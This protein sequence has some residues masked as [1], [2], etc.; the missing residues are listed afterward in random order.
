MPPALI[1]DSGS[2]VAARDVLHVVYTLPAPIA[3]L[4]F[5]TRPS[6]TTSCS[7]HRPQATLTIAR[8][9]AP[10]RR[11][12]RRHVGA[13]HLGSAM[14]HHPH[15]H[16]IVPGGGL[17]DDGRTWIA[18]RPKFF[19]PVRVLSRLFRR[20]VDRDAARRPRR[21]QAR[22]LRHAHQPRSTAAAFAALLAPLEELR[23]GRLCEETVRRARSR[24]RLS[25]ALHPPRRHLEPPTGRRRRAHRRV[26]VQGLSH[27]RRR[28]ASRS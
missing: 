18:C 20:L 19:L 4:A 23:M 14:T 12:D 22:L 9:Q 21:R 15:V 8:R 13:A 5:T 25:L 1:A 28:P 2:R 17:S 7:G 27:R 24:A 26:Q 6:S 11:Q 16:M 3:D 10:S